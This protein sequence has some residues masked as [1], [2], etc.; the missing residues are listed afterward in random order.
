M[1]LLIITLA[2]STLA[3]VGLLRDDLG[4]SAPRG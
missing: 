2:L 1:E 4:G 3:F